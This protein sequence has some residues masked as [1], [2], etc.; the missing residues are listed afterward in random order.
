MTVTVTDPT[1]SPPASVPFYLLL[2]PSD[3]G[4]LV[5]DILLPLTGLFG[6]G[7]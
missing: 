6:G 7:V 5:D 3:R 4:Y 2:V 1:S